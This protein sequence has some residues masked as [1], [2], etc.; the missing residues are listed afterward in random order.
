MLRPD[1]ALLA[2]SPVLLALG[3]LATLLLA[4]PIVRIAGDHGTLSFFV[5]LFV[6][7]AG[8][9]LLLARIGAAISRSADLSKQVGGDESSAKDIQG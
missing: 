2:Q 6:V 4:W 5:Y 3:L 1:N 7:W 9:V 8:L